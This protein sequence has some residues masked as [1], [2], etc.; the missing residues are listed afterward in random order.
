M[1]ARYGF[2][3]NGDFIDRSVS[4]REMDL[5]SP[6]TESLSF[7]VPEAGEEDLD[8]AIAAAR[9]AFD[10]GPWPRMSTKERAEVLTAACDALES[11]IESA[12]Q[13]Q[14]DEMGGPVTLGRMTARSSIDVVRAMTADVVTYD[15]IDA[16][17]GQWEYQMRTSPFGVVAAISPW[18][19][20][21]AATVMKGATALLAGCTVVDKPPI[22]APISSL[23]FAEALSEAGLPDGAFNLVA[24]DGK[25]GE[26]LVSSG[27]I[28]MISFTGGTAV[29]KAI[30]RIAGEQLKRVVLELGGKSAAVVLPDGD[31]GAAV[32]AVASGVF[33]N[34]GQ[35]CSS[36]TRLF[37]PADQ[38]DE[39]AERLAAFAASLRVG[40]PHDETTQLGPLATRRQY[41]RVSGYAK[42]G[43]EEGA[44]LA[45]GGARP[46][47]FDRGFFFAPT[48]FAGVRNSMRLAQE[49]IFGPIASVLTYENID[50]AADQAND[51]A[52]GLNGAVF[53]ADEDRAIAFAE[54]L[55]TG[56][57]TINGFAQN[58]SAPRHH[59]KD[60]GVGV[61]TG[62][63]GYDA[64]R[65]QKLYNLRPAATA[66]QNLK[67]VS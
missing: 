54:R 4:G 22:E 38:A 39:A 57:V 60:S 30:G 32:N 34:T 1:D 52:Y 2:F 44:R 65:L 29:G 35:V 3:I 50:D 64:H 56:A 41:E 17:T 63:E 31:L 10:E 40:D 18:N 6:S 9:R 36:L 7:R 62:R 53:S 20:P 16:R 46:A 28:D 11:R 37:V 33:F 23:L 26:R 14:A 43:Q 25:L 49:E 48:V 19:G 27:G 15:E 45:V 42:L 51:S 61:R 58:F 24:G 5:I 21:F 47:E 66:M 8:S 67:V 59:I 12:A 55:R 13:I